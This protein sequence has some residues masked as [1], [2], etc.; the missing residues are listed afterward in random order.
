MILPIYP[1][2]A[3]RIEDIDK[4]GMMLDYSFLW[5]TLTWPAATIPITEVAQDEQSLSDSFN[6]GWT[7]LIDKTL[8][9]GVGLPVS[10]QVVA[11]SW[12]DEKVLAVMKAIDDK[13]KYRKAPVA[14]L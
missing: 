13:I 7:K 12:E 11:H 9:G 5:N 3:P 4:M 10:I 14:G 6:D 1:C 8:K 2:C